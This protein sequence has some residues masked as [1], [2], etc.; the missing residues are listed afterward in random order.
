MSCAA[1]CLGGYAVG[2][3]ATWAGRHRLL[4]PGAARKHAGNSVR[5]MVDR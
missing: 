5:E 4:E 1:T 3:G 2:S